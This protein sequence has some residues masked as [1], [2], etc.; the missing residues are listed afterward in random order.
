M[1]KPRKK[2]ERKSSRAKTTRGPA[3]RYDGLPEPQAP[4]QGRET[5]DLDLAPGQLYY[6]DNLDVLR[7]HIKDE[8]VDLV[9]L[10]PPFKSNQ[11]YNVL[12]ETRD[13]TKAAAQIQA[14]E[15]TWQWSL[16]AEESYA[17]TMQAGGR[18]AEAMRAFRIFLGESDMMA[19]LAMMAPRLLELHRALKAT[20]SLFLH[21]DPTASHYLKIVLDAVFHPTSFRNEI[22]WKR[23]QAHNSARRFGPVHD[24]IFYYAKGRDVLWNQQYQA[25]SKEYIE[26]KFKKVDEAT[27]ERFQD[28]T[29]TG[30]GIRKGDSGKSWRGHDPTKSGRHWQPASY[31]YDKYEALTGEPLGNYPLLERLDRLDDVGMI[32]WPKKKG[33]S[34]RYKQFLCD[35]PGVPAQDVWVDIDPINSRAAERLGYPTQKPITLLE[36]ILRA[37]TN[38]GD[39]VLDPFCGC[40]T[41]IDAAQRMERSWIG[42]DI[43]HL[44]IG[45]VKHRIRGAFPDSSFSVLGEPTTVEGA[46]QLAKDDPYQFQWWILGLVGARGTEQKKGADRG[47]DG[48]LYFQEPDRREETRE[49][50]LSV[51]AGRP[52]VSHV[53]DLR[54]VM[55]RE[56]AVIG[57]LLLMKDPTAAM[58]KEAAAAGFYDS[59]V[60]RHPRIQILTAQELLKGASLDYPAPRHSNVTYRR[61][62]RVVPPT[63]KEQLRLRLGS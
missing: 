50:V 5:S 43:T 54:G 45:L 41:T 55:E 18:L 15:D 26:S 48:R 7:R 36:R 30:P 13:G 10:D 3:Q 11:D 12:F 23:T 29:L 28:V 60:G 27:G 16:E 2:A 52:S 25:Y 24:V 4:F 46:G 32:Y 6:G 49:I 42:I 63:K 38:P 51:K 34:P 56:G 9:Y 57:A 44:S 1:A 19:Y 59:P 58:K 47:I 14:F 17:E 8:S 35:A 61:M 20:G 62:T 21:C 39:V 33:G 31:V 40:G 37:S 53:R 22:I